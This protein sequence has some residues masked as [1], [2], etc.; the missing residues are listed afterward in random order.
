[1][2]MQGCNKFLSWPQYGQEVTNF[3]ISQTNLERTT[4][5]GD[6][7]VGE[8]KKTSET[9]LSTTGHEKSCGNLGRPLSKA[10][11]SWTPIANQYCEG[12]VKSTPGGEWNRPETVNLQAVEGSIRRANCVPIEEWAG[13]LI[14]AAR[15]RNFN[16]GAIA[17][18]SLNRAIELFELDPKPSDL[19][20]ARLKPR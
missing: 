9:L 20:L 4:G 14:Y 1:M 16:S 18:A 19:P 11:Y 2:S 5:E 15:L 17:K 7:P 13:E 10:K 8:N 6:S 3:F 12:K